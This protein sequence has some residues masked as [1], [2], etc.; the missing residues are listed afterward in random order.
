MRA[1]IST[2]LR[3]MLFRRFRR[4]ML[5]DLASVRREDAE[6]DDELLDVDEDEEVE[7]EDDDEWRPAMPRAQRET[8][9]STT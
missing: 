8:A 9:C 5:N 2:S 1:V 3:V 7:E 4:R 6:L